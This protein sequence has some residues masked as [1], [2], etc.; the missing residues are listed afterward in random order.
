MTD[1]LTHAEITE[2]ARL[3]PPGRPMTI[4]LL[5]DAG[6][7]PSL[8][9]VNAA[10]ALE[11]W[12][13]VN[14]EIL[15]GTIQDGRR[16]VIA[17]AAARYPYNKVLTAAA[18]AP[19]R[20]LFVGASPTRLA[21]IR[22]DR[23][24]RRIRQAAGPLTVRDCPAATVTDLNMIRTERP[25]I[26]HIA[27]HGRGPGLVFDD[28]AGGSH[29][30]HAKAIAEALATYRQELN[31][32]LH[33]IVLNACTSEQAGELLLPHADVVLAH[34]DELEDDDGIAFAGALYQAL[35]DSPGLAA[36]ARIAVRELVRDNPRHR[37]LTTGLVIFE[38]GA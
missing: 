5:K 37:R 35:P 18:P 3:F 33:G 27:S 29:T 14:S 17:G 22:A 11:F 4:A 1:G 31:L 24:L 10:N 19:R 28:G 16:R 23:E 30:V 6:L 2:L 20:L 7:D 32:R 15:G 34:R 8:L 38:G 21:P 9:P 26:L 36:A 13:A 25:D 12:L